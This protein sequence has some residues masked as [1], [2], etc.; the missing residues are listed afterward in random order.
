MDTDIDVRP[1]AASSFYGVQKQP[2]SPLSGAVRNA[3]FRTPERSANRFFTSRR[4]NNNSS[5]KKSPFRL[6]V[7]RS[8]PNRQNVQKGPIRTWQ[9]ARTASLS[10][11]KKLKVIEMDGDIENRD[12][13]G[14][15]R[16]V[17]GHSAATG[18]ASDIVSLYRSEN[19][20]QILMPRESNSVE[21]YSSASEE[22]M[23][24]TV[25]PVPLKNLKN[26][27]YLNSV[28]QSLIAFPEMMNDIRDY[29]IQQTDPERGFGRKQLDFPITTAL[30][31]LHSSYESERIRYGPRDDSPIR[32]IRSRLKVLKNELGEMSRQ[33]HSDDQQDAGECYSILVEAVSEE[34]RRAGGKVVIEDWLKMETNSHM[35]CPSCKWQSQPLKSEDISTYLAI[36]DQKEDDGLQLDVQ[37]LLTTSLYAIERREYNCQECGSNVVDYHRMVTKAPPIVVIQLSRTSLDGSKVDTLVDVNRRLTL[38]VG[39]SEVHESRIKTVEYELRSSICHVGPSITKGHYFSLTLN[40]KDNEWYDCDDDDIRKKDWEYVAYN[41]RKLGCCLFYGKLSDQ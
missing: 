28:V 14:A 39:D 11:E 35:I 26:S 19:R 29:L 16:S 5:E 31:K 22:E 40:P 34:M 30:V 32:N 8:T 15:C 25:T 38:H 7:K 37:M 3:N 6:G 33:F 27:C 36:P 20:A 21:Q 4:N 2:R 23:K 13:V 24:S 10:E 18:A 17:A 41:S 12:P 1:A 9:E